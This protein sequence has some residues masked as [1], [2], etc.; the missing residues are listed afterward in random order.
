MW[1][2]VCCEV[3]GRGH[4]KT[5]TPCQDKTKILSRDGA[6]VIA[7]SDG[8]G[9]AS[10]SHFG[11]ECV[12][13]NISAYV[14]DNFRQLIDNVDG[15]QVKLDIMN[16]L[17]QS[18]ND[19]AVELNCDLKDLAST[20]LLAAVCEEKYIIIHI[21][22][23]VIGYLDGEELKVA[24]SPDNGEF[25]NVTTFVTSSEALASMRLFKGNINN[26]SGFILMSDGTEQSLYHKPT[27][28]LA[29]V[30]IKLMHRTCLI[31]GGIM[32]S[33]LV[34]TFKSVI[35]KNTQD[36]CSIAIMARPF[37]VLRSLEELTYLERHELYSECVNKKKIFKKKR[38]RKKKDK[39]EIKQIDNIL[40]ILTTSKTYEQVAS[41]INL[42]PEDVRVMLDKLVLSG[43]VIRSHDGIYNRA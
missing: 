39:L 7:L 8:A 23:G 15:K 11:A 27:K 22:D 32:R 4:I 5:E 34:E 6:E 16:I 2:S 20:L 12:V 1:K 37:G 3:Q 26:I 30:T 29:K 14:A 17:K 18:L 25:A 38:I 42:K 40:G 24:S 28:A 19:K 21:G 33:R 43:L 36:D 31:D 10:H 13:N 9:S 41:E 35:L